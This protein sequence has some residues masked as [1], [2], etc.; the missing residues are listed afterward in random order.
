MVEGSGF[1]ASG[2]RLMLHSRMPV[3][4]LCNENFHDS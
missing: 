2:M 3:E 1:R 4:T